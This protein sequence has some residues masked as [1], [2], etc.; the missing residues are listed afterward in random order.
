MNLPPRY[1]IL[2]KSAQ[3]GGFGA[4]IPLED[5]YLRR[6]V[7]LKV[8]QDSAHN[9]QLENE[10]LS[11]CRARSR[12]VVEVYD[13]VKSDKGD[14]EGLIIERLR[15]RDFVDFHKEAAAKPDVYL[16]VLYQIAVALS[17]LHRAG[18]VHRD[19]KLDNF[20]ESAAGVVKLFDFG[21]SSPD[22]GYQT[23][24]NKGTLYYAAPELYEPGATITAE[25]DIYAFGVCA[26]SLAKASL[27]SELKE[28]PPQKSGRCPSIGAMGALGLHGEIVSLIDECLNPNPDLRPK[29]ALLSATFA[30]HLVSGR[31]R[32]LFVQ[33]K[34]KVGE[35]STQQSVA[36][37][38]IGNLGQ[39]RVEYDG[40]VFRVTEVGGS[41]RI[42]N[43]QANVGDVLHDAC[44]LSFGDRALGAGQ[45]WVTFFSSHP[46]VVL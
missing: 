38:R 35:L 8:M 19:L 21:I 23:K 42:N 34:A 31:H 1:K 18:V 16:K 9:A 26:W 20:K 25:M 46:E 44:L 2:T 32:G 36:A 15:G 29:A 43:A 11:L 33:G 24:E 28:L 40:L 4:V 5:A 41:V 27:P 12:H 3:V 37:L 39:L 14:I 17:D 7:L 30:K 6:I 10:I 13:V 22:G 45:Q